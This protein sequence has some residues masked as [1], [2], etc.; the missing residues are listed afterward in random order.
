MF[1][2]FI[3]TL[4]YDRHEFWDIATKQHVDY[5][6]MLTNLQKFIA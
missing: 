3:L 4:N 2:K 5:F 6:F 1:N